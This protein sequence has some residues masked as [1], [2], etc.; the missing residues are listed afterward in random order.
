MS[1][2]FSLKSGLCPTYAFDTRLATFPLSILETEISP[3]VFLPSS[4]FS[5]FWFSFSDEIH[6]AINRR[7]LLPGAH[8]HSFP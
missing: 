4:F 1:Q 5:D 7:L 3:P 6:H 8:E 2:A